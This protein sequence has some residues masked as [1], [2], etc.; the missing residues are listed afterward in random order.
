MPKP[1]PP[2]PPEFRAEA[3]PTTAGST[4]RASLG[5][6]VRQSASAAQW[7]Q[8]G[9]GYGSLAVANPPLVRYA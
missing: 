1:K 9:I 8:R 3:T 5:N 4:P 7:D 2:Y 6:A